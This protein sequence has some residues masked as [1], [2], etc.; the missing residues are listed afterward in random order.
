MGHE[1]YSATGLHELRQIK[2]VYQALLDGALRLVGV[3]AVFFAGTLGFEAVVFVLVVFLAPMID[4]F[5]GARFAAVFL[6]GAAG[7]VAFFVVVELFFTD[8]AA[9]LAAGL[10]GGLVVFLAGAAFFVPEER[11]GVV[12]TFFERTGAGAFLAGLA[13]GLDFAA[14]A[15][16]F[17]AAALGLRGGGGG[18]A[19]SLPA[20][21]R[22]LGDSLTLPD[23]PLGK[24]NTPFS[25]PLAIALLILVT[26]VALISSP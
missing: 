1:V 7:F 16:G 9:G 10:V 11:F 19:F 14:A 17:L 4:F 23:G 25:A 26:T 12:A 6:A 22:A 24:A 18:V 3:V 13:T 8:L 5:A 20:S 2:H 15:F 21:D